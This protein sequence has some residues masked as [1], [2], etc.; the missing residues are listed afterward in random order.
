M[1]TRQDTE[2]MAAFDNNNKL[3]ALNHGT[4]FTPKETKPLAVTSL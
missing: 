2:S 1:N 3:P 4:Y